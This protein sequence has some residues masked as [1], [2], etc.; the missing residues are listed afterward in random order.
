MKKLKNSLYELNT[1]ISELTNSLDNNK[2]LHKDWVDI[3]KIIIEIDKE[4]FL[5]SKIEPQQDYRDGSG[6]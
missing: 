3:Q 5:K 1:K 4:I 6:Y 2:N